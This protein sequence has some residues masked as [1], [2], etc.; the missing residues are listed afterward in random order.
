M[1]HLRLI[2]IALFL[3][4]SLRL[5]PMP[6][7]D[8]VRHG[9]LATLVLL[10]GINGRLRLNIGFARRILPLVACLVFASLFD[11]MFR[12]FGFYS[13]LIWAQFLSGL[14]VANTVYALRPD[15]MRRLL[16]LCVG[17]LILQGIYLKLAP[18]SF[19]ARG[20]AIGITDSFTLYGVSL[21]R[22][23]F[24]YFQ[25]NSAAYAIFYMLICWFVTGQKTRIP[26]LQFISVAL[27]LVTFVILTQSRG[28]I[29]LL[30][31]F[32]P[33]WYLSFRSSAAVTFVAVGGLLGLAILPLS[34]AFRALWL[35]REGSNAERLAALGDY[36]ELILANPLNGLGTDAIVRRTEDIGLTP[37][38][39]FFVELLGTYGVVFGGFIVAYLVYALILRP[40]PLPMRVAGLFGISVSLFNNTLMTTW[41]FFPLL[42]PVMMTT[43]PRRSSGF[44]DPVHRRAGHSAPEPATPKPGTPASP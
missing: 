38:Q 22:F 26:R 18:D 2:L 41:A 13:M 32:L 16:L 11:L 29:L 31:G 44:P 20:A 36:F 39:V 21:K 27:I 6:L 17:I 37:S 40:A 34:E 33:A 3:T 25:P 30:A 24:A 19:A 9:F 7:S 42:V 35:L 12:E 23:Y 10:S 1:K 14:F 43:W 5:V 4:A 15:D 8:T 28:A